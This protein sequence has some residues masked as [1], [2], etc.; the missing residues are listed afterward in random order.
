[1]KSEEDKAMNTL[2]VNNSSA[3][4]LLQ[5]ADGSWTI[6]IPEVEETYHSRHGAMQESLH[7]FI[8]NGLHHCPLEKM[9]ILEVGLGTG[10]N[11]ILTLLN[12]PKSIDY[13][14]IEPYPIDKKLVEEL[15]ATSESNAQLYRYIHFSPSE[16][17]IF[18]SDHFTLKKYPIKLLDFD[19][20]KRFD[21]IYYDAFGPRVEPTLWTIEAMQKCYDL[22]KP[23]GIWVSYCAKGE[24]RR[25]LIALG[26][27][28]ERIPGPPGK[29]EMLRAKK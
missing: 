14:G 25:N 15:M 16:D 29:R 23:G 26:F 5:T 8:N 13:H 12:T 28:V 27:Q 2:L 3:R 20:E 4:K 6:H 22:L 11:V 17:L 9:S 18:L 19:T 10:L 21:V 1:M 24:V 7:V